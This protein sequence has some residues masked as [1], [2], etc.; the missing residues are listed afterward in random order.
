VVEE[1]MTVEE[2]FDVEDDD[3]VLL[4]DEEVLLVEVDELT[5]VLAGDEKTPESVVVA[6][7]RLV[8]RLPLSMYTPEIYQS[9]VLESPRRRTPTCQ[10]ALLVEVLAAWLAMTR[11]RGADPVL[12]QRPTVLAEKLMS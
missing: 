3:E 10:S 9:S 1:V 7:P 12:A 4:V 5:E 11:A 2:V 8:V 6:A